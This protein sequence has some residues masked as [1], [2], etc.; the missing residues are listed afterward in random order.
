MHRI[1]SWTRA[2]AFVERN[3]GQQFFLYYPSTLPRAALQVKDAD[4]EPYAKLGWDAQPYLGEQGHFP[5]PAPRAAHAAMVSRLDRDVGALL[6]RLQK[7][8]LDEDTL[9]IFAS[10][11]GPSDVGGF[12]PEFFASKAGPIGDLQ[13]SGGR[14]R[15]GR[16]FLYEG[17]IR[18]PLIVQWPGKIAAG[19]VLEQA[20]GFQDLWPTI[21]AIL[22]QPLP[23]KL[24]GV[25]FAPALFGGEIQSRSIPLYWEIGRSQALRVGDWK[26]MRKVDSQGRE[27]AELYD[28]ATDPGETKNLA[29]SAPEDLAR[30]IAL[31]RAARRPSKTFPSPFDSGL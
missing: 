25:S 19:S 24:D 26:L 18:V 20:V 4:L 15:G 13:R 17:G 7:L 3:A 31:A 2:L 9:V 11:N 1:G 21:A 14:F 28:L 29:Q 6:E 5:H 27:L 16:G 23:S 12:D 30:L 10:G 8:G 22:D